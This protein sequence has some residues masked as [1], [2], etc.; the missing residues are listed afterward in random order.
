MAKYI[1][2][3]TCNNKSLRLSTGWTNPPVIPSGGHF[4]FL[5]SGS[6]V[7]NLTWGPPEY[8]GGESV[9]YYTVTN[10]KK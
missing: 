1:F 5:P 4:R 8:T 2:P 6:I 9:Q 7:I 10:T 3:Y